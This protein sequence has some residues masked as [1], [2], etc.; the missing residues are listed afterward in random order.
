MALQLV[1]GE[2]H[3]VTVQVHPQLWGNTLQS[4]APE[5]PGP[6]MAEI[7]AW[8]ETLIPLP[9]HE[10]RVVLQSFNTVVERYQ[11]LK[12]AE[13]SA[14]H[15]AGPYHCCAVMSALPKF[16]VDKAIKGT[17][18]GLLVLTNGL[19]N[20]RHFGIYAHR[21]RSTSQEKP[22]V[23]RS[24][25]FIRTEAVFAKTFVCFVPAT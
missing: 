9:E 14:L 7:K 17:G 21:S 8:G 25:K 23:V 10:Y 6:R 22:S 18:I 11:V 2:G 4:A 19:D 15:P 13:E 20:G 3:V 24:A 12:W 1:V 16:I 5:T